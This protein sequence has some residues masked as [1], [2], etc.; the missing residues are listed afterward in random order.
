MGRAELPGWG[1]AFEGGATLGL[2]T[3]RSAEGVVIGVN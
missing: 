2:V 1:D 3:G